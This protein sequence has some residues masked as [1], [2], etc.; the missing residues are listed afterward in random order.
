[1]KAVIQVYDKHKVIGELLDILDPSYGVAFLPSSD[2]L[3]T[4]VPIVKLRFEG[5]MQI[6]YKFE[7]E[8]L[9]RDISSM[10]RK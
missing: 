2:S 9:F 8:E 7:R 6:F 5:E 4:R 1:V 3:Q 10:V